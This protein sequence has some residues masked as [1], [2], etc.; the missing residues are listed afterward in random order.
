MEGDYAETSYC[1][2]I[3]ACRR[4]RSRYARALPSQELFE[5]RKVCLEQAR[6][7]K[8]VN[9]VQACLHGAGIC[10]LEAHKQWRTIALMPGARCHEDGRTFAVKEVLMKELGWG[11]AQR[12]GVKLA[13][14]NRS[15]STLHSRRQND[16]SRPSRTLEG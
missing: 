6:H 13:G 5:V 11:L 3:A 1:G 12:D 10:E 14:A 16:S 7:F 15:N 2:T 9:R 8:G 4:S